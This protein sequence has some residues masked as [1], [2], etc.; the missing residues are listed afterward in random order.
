MSRHLRKGLPHPTPPHPPKLALRFLDNLRPDS[1]EAV[2]PARDS[3]SA[4]KTQM[5]KGYLPG[6]VVP[7]LS[8][9][10]RPLSGHPGSPKGEVREHT[11]PWHSRYSI[12]SL[13]R[14]RASWGFHRESKLTLS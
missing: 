2:E 11:K 4:R 8:V 12:S 6:R 13:A 10:G 5:R 7:S 14:Q 3:S 9:L 1:D